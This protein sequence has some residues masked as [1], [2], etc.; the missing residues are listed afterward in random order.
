MRGMVRH[1]FGPYVIGASCKRCASEFLGICFAYSYD[2]WNQRIDLRGVQQIDDVLAAAQADEVRLDQSYGPTRDWVAGLPGFSEQF[3]KTADV[4]LAVQQQI[5]QGQPATPAQRE[6]VKAALSQLHASLSQ[7]A[8]QLESGVQTLALA[9]QKQSDYRERIRQAISISTAASQQDLEMAAQIARTAPCNDGV[10]QQVK[11]IR[12]DFNGALQRL[13]QEFNQLAQASGDAE[14]GLAVLL[15][16]V[17]NSRTQMQNVLNLVQ[18]AKDD[19]IGSFLEQL[20]LSAAKKQ[21]ED[22]ATVQ[23]QAML[24][25]ASP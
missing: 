6:Q 3:G 4:V 20:H 7:S 17:V 13:S 24:A 25:M 16:A 5:R 8:G 10:L 19:Q 15:G 21:W 11:N 9:L 14:R 23:N 2:A 12:T 1:S 22:L 18:A